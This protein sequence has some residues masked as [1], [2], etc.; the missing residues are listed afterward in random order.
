M[1]KGNPCKYIKLSR[2]QKMNYET[3]QLPHSVAKKNPLQPLEG[4]NVEG[5]LMVDPYQLIIRCCPVAFLL[6]EQT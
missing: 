5:R 4:K 6:V 3:T 2:S 1:V